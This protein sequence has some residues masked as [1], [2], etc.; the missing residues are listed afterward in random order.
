MNFSTG[1]GDRF[2]GSRITG[3]ILRHVL[4]DGEGGHYFKFCIS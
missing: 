1:F 2:H 4:N 3:D